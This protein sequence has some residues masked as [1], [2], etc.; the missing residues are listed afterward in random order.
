MSDSIVIFQGTTPCAVGM[1]LLRRQKL[2]ISQL[3]NFCEQNPSP[4]IQHRL[5]VLQE[6]IQTI[7]L[8][9]DGTH[10]YPCNIPMQNGVTEW[11]SGTFVHCCVPG[12]DLIEGIKTGRHRGQFEN[13]NPQAIIALQAGVH[14]AGGTR[15]NGYIAFEVNKQD[16]E[17]K[18][19]NC[20]RSTLINRPA[21]ATS[22]DEKVRVIIVSSSLGGFASGSLTSLEELVWAIAQDMQVE[23]QFC[24]ILLI[25]GG[26]NIGKDRI[27][28]LA[29]TAA[30]FK[31][32]VAISTGRHKHRQRQ[33][34]KERRSS[35]LSR[36][37]PS[38]L[39]SDVN[40]ADTP[41]GLMLLDQVS[42][43]SQLLLALVSTP[44]GS[45]RDSQ[46]AD[47]IVKAS[48]MT[49]TGEPKFGISAG[50]STIY[51][52]RERLKLYA[53]FKLAS[54]I[55]GQLVISVAEES[56]QQDVQDFILKQRLLAGRREQQLLNRLLEEPLESGNHL[57]TTRVMGLIDS[58]T[59]P[60]KGM[61][62]LLQGESQVWLAFQQALQPED[63]IDT[64]LEVRQLH[65]VEFFQADL[66][67]IILEVVQ[68]KSLTA[69]RQF[70]GKLRDVIESIATEAA[71]DLPQFERELAQQ[72]TNVNNFKTQTIPNLQQLLHQQRSWLDN[73]VNGKKHRL[74]ITFEI[75]KAGWQ[76]LNCLKQ[77]LRAWL[78]YKA[79][80]AVVKTLT[81]LQVPI[82]QLLAQTQ[83]AETTA[84]ALCNEFQQN[85]E[86]I[87]THEPKFECP[88]GLCLLRT[89][90]DLQTYY[91]QILP[92]GEESSAVAEVTRLILQTPDALMLLTD[93]TE[94]ETKL[95][96]QVEALLQPQLNRLHVVTE[97]RRRFPNQRDLGAVLR[98]R[99]RESHEFIQLKD[100]CDTENGIYLLRLLGIDQTQAGNLPDILRQYGYHRST[101]YEVVNTADPEQIIF[102]QERAVFP[103]TAWAHYPSALD[104]YRNVS[105][106]T[107]FEKLHTR[108]GERYLPTPG[109]CLTLVDAQSMVVRAWLLDRI[110]PRLQSDNYQI[111]FPADPPIPLEKSLD[112]L[113]SVTGYRYGVDII[114]H[115]SN[116]FLQQG[117]E[118]LYRR[119]M[120]LLSVRHGKVTPN[121]ATDKAVIQFFDDEIATLL[122]EQLEWWQQNSVPEAMEWS[123]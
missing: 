100:N 102:F 65:L 74:T 72:Q 7:A 110:Q 41:Q 49:V 45:R 24:C 95:I 107:P 67:K 56:I 18:I 35:K 104:A 84:I 105:Q 89:V 46:T 75:E 90:E 10:I 16:L 91:P 26:A 34:G 55:L 117:A 37:V 53:A 81:Q 113:C 32:L 47:F 97:L 30:L 63:N 94:L 80:N 120:Y 25:P 8:D 48:E 103:L 4:E 39:I 61:E 57:C 119:L 1:D 118:P 13:F 33:A 31:E 23:I 76:Y 20:F 22:Q 62:R 19:R 92:D 3:T 27:N 17:R 42:M 99:D 38:I 98:Q 43:V 121:N 52:G 87:A 108:V 68:T 116:L 6:H 28:S 9:V 59:Q 79:Q 122:Q 29:I 44:L 114:S 123:I 73:L 12:A 66:Q 14:A 40:H 111:E 71:K 50:L 5:T 51:L 11:Q 109:E 60:L 70:L 82:G 115:F 86:Q 2:E 54:T 15:A 21:L 69:A 101:D 112:T 96:T 36:H 85:V 93:A 77:Q 88:N 78:R 58:Y 83:Q 64:V 106:R